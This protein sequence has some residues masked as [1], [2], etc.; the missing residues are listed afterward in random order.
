MKRRIRT[1]I[2]TTFVAA[3]AALGAV[4]VNA[5]PAGAG[6]PDGWQLNSALYMG[7]CL[8]IDTDT[9]ANA[10]SNV[11]QYKCRLAGDWLLPYQRFMLTE[12]PGQ[13]SDIFQLRNAKTGRCVTYTAGIDRA[14]PVWAEACG[15]AG[16]GWRWRETNV[17]GAVEVTNNAGLCLTPL[18]PAQFEDQSGIRLYSCGAKWILR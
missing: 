18:P 1:R 4:L 13:P 3:V 9:L 2:A 12:I 10:R 17:L 8:D 15:T 5:A 16:Q 7:S 14:A 11:Q 6:G